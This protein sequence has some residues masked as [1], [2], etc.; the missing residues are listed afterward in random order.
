MGNGP[1]MAD[2]LASLLPKDYLIR[3]VNTADLNT[4]TQIAIAR[5][6]DYFIGVHGA[7]LFLTI[8]T[9]IM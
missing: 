2:K 7:G 1:E 9:F 6:T 5:N 4:F 8:F 3:L